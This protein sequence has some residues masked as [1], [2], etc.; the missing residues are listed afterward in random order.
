MLKLVIADPDVFSSSLPVPTDPAVHTWRNPDG[1][2]WAHGC[3]VCAQH[4]MHVPD[5]ARYRF[6][7]S[8]SEVLAF[9]EP[10][11]PRDLV[12]DV[13]RRMV[14][15]VAIQSRGWEVLHASAVLMPHGIVAFCAH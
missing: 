11:V 5:V 7:D 2:V 4:W 12:R 10:C 9:A 13:Y 3:T 1:T 8:T 15:P 14:L 6:G